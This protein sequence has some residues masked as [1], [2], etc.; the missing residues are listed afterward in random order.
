[1]LLPTSNSSRHASLQPNADLNQ[2][3]DIDQRVRYTLLRIYSKYEPVLLSGYLLF[4]FMIVQITWH[5][6]E[7]R[8]TLIFWMVLNI[9][10]VVHALWLGSR[11]KKHEHQ[12]SPAR[13]VRMRVYSSLAFGLLWGMGPALF[14]NHSD[15]TNLVTFS[16]LILGVLSASAYFLSIIPPLFHLFFVPVLLC[17]SC[18]V[19]WAEMHIIVA[20]TILFLIFLTWMSHQIHR[21]MFAVYAARYENELLAESLRH[22]KEQVEKASRAKT[23]FLAAASHDLRQPLQ[24]QRLFAE[25]IKARSQHTE[26]SQLGSQLIE[27]QHAMQLMLDELLDI[28]R[29]DAGIVSPNLCGISLYALFIRLHADFTPLAESKGL[30]FH[31]HW[32]SNDALVHCD[33]ALLDRILLNLLNNAI[34]Y[35]HTGSVMLAARQRGQ[36]WRIEVRDSGIGIPIHQQ[37]DIFEEF[38]Q[39]DN[40]AR[41]RSKGLGLGLSIVQRLCQLLTYPLSLTSRPGKGSVFAIE[42]P[43]W[44][45]PIIRDVE[46]ASSFTALAGLTALAIDDDQAI[47]EALKASLQTFGIIVHTSANRDEAIQILGHHA[48]DVMI[49]DYRLPDFDNGLSVIESLRSNSNHEIPAILLTGDTAPEKLIELGKTECTVLHKPVSLNNLLQAIQESIPQ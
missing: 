6:A 1:M 19:F 42:I 27:S 13:W 36:R 15:M 37:Q 4:V 28:S 2:A 3:K 38:R 25:A 7:I 14:M 26:L 5:T 40:A 8:T 30:T 34:R 24:A 18:I 32:P 35:T 22:E 29:L 10:I 11:F 9:I 46:T 47:R 48:P 23:R 49:V 16:V 44:E 12:Y 33:P 31:V 20:A 17:Y 41:D 45:G 21:M 43:I 39:L